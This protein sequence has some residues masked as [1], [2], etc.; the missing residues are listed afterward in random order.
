VDGD[1][2]LRVVG[3]VLRRDSK[4][5]AGYFMSKGVLRTARGGTLGRRPVLGIV[6][7]QETPRGRYP[8]LRSRIV[9]DLSSVAGM[10]DL[11]VMVLNDVPAGVKFNVLQ[12]SDGIYA[13]SWAERVL[14]EDL[15]IM[16][17]LDF[18]MV[19][20]LMTEVGGNG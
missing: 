17:Y 10:H 5:V 20:E 6:A 19:E 15:A 2:R 3:K 13:S 9:S 14:F 7:S 8:E 12:H 4:V 18:Q 11:D 1:E 16:E